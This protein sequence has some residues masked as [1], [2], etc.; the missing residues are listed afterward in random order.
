MGKPIV[1]ED[2]LSDTNSTEA[3]RN[4]DAK[5]IEVDEEPAFF[6]QLPKSDG[7]Q[8]EEVFGEVQVLTE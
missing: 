2:C 4:S 3:E 6:S 1:I 8:K 7:D 5:L